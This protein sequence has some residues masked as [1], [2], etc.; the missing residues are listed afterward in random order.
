[1][2]GLAGVSL[3]SQEMVATNTAPRPDAG[4]SSQGVRTTEAWTSY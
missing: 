2:L 4:P 1:M 3:Y